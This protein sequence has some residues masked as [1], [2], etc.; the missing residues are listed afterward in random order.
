MAKILILGGGFGGVVAAESLA[1]TLPHDHE[2]SLVS[3][4]G[5][6]VFYPA[7]VRFAFGRCSAGDITFDLREALLNRRIRFIRGEVARIKPYDQS[8]TLAG[9]D[10]V[11]DVPYD[12]LII[13]LGRR[14]ATERVTG[15]FE[16]AH[17]LLTLESAQKF[18]HAVREFHGGHAVVGHC[19]DARNPIPAFE[20]AFA[21][22]NLLAKRNQREGSRITVVSDQDLDEMFGGVSISE[23]LNRA[24][25]SHGV[26]F[27]SGF[28][29]RS[30]TPGSVVA[31]DGRVIDCN[32]R[33]LIPPFSGPGPIIGT[34]L[35]NA[36]GYVAVDSTM[37]VRGHNRIYAAG[38][39]VGF[40]GPKMGHMAVRQGEVVGENLVAQI[41][42]SPA[43]I[44][45][46]H[47]LMLVL[48][49]GD[50]ESIFVHQDLW[51]DEPA[52][53]SQNRFWSWAKRIHE[54]IWKASHS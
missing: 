21:L 34:D 47:E 27:I 29:I 52:N 4:S 14:L 16:N 8:V 39:C 13:A 1:M 25:H 48:D 41:K 31:K 49:S 3:R 24:L 42:Q 38:D 22:A 33:M 12:Y 50:R 44:S 28:E 40:P 6:F 45:Y 5:E 7:L 2:I 15:F 36:E 10:I 26:N 35:T 53:M 9:G 32:L 19:P 17:H 30:V 11:G 46:D 54:A 51:S 18:A 37:K 20:T 43:T 23:P